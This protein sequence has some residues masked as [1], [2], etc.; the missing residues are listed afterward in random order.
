MPSTIDELIKRRVIQQW[1]D[2]IPRDKIAADNNVGAGTV[3]GIIN[4]YN[5]QLQDSVLLQ[6]KS[7]YIEAIDE[8]L[9]LNEALDERGISTQDIDNL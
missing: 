6:T 7:A 9:T 2:G 3:S 1:L 5:I 4:N 8:Y